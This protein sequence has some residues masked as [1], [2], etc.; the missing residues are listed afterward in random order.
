MFS[1]VLCHPLPLSRPHLSL[2]RNLLLSDLLFLY[3]PLSPSEPKK[4]ISTDNLAAAAAGDGSR[5]LPAP[6]KGEEEENLYI[7]EVEEMRVSPVVSR[8]GYLN[9]MEEKTKG[10]VKR[11]VVSS[12]SLKIYACVQSQTGHALA[13]DQ[14][15][16][17]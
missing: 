11:W 2:Y 15:Y 1:N 4:S 17:G 6:G 14:R 13:Q 5:K 3:R 12:V 10:W 9:F 8:K 16:Q 7:P